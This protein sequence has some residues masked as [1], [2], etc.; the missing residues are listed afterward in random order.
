[1]GRVLVCWLSYDIDIQFG[2]A[3][4]GIENEVGFESRGMCEKAGLKGKWSSVLNEDEDDNVSLSEK[5]EV[6][7]L[8]KTSMAKAVENIEAI[9]GILEANTMV[10]SIIKKRLKEGKQNPGT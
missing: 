8:V 10:V 7:E 1:M 6:V 3:L 4:G 9:C 5:L 2:S